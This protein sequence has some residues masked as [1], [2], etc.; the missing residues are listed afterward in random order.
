MGIELP[1]RLILIAGL[2]RGCVAAPRFYEAASA[3]TPVGASGDVGLSDD[4]R[5]QEMTAK[6]ESV[7]TY[8]Q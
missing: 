4:A 1:L 3:P 5:A 7:I 2:A 6:G 8:D